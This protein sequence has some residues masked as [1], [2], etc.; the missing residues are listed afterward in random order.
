MHEA[1]E[2]PAPGRYG[3][4]LA[5]TVTIDGQTWMADAG[6]GVA[7]HEPIPLRAGV[8]R[9]GPFT[10][11]LERLGEIPG[12]WRFVHDPALTSFYAMDFTVAPAPWADF[13]PHPA[14]LSARPESPFRRLGPMHPP[15]P[16][17]AGSLL[18]GPLYP[19]PGG[20][21]TEREIKSQQEWFDA[22]TDLFGLWLGS[23]TDGDRGTLWTRIQASHQAWLAARAQVG[24]RAT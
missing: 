16:R 15:A 5:V 14:E 4:H 9:Q 10:F 19:P 2:T 21:R 8:Y 13:L 1:D 7:H 12:G 23:L 24:E 17:G 22:A 6:L 11:G 3:N 18:S 20:S